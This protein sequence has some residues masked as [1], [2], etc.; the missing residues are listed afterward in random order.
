MTHDNDIRRNLESVQARIAAACARVGRDVASVELLPVSKTVD[1]ARIRLAYEAGCRTFGENKVQEA[2]A[3][4]ERLADLN[5]RWSVIGRLQTNKAKYVARMAHE[6]QALGS[7]KLAEELQRRLEIEGRVL[8]VYIQINSSGEES[9]Y[10]LAPSD[11][12]AF[13]REMTAFERL[14]VKGLMTLAVFSSDAA[15]VRACF[16][17]MR[18]LRERLRQDG[19]PGLSFEGLSMGMSGDFEIAIEEGSTLVRVGQAIFGARALPD[20]HYWPGEGP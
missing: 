19:P 18:D 17:V 8:D 10:G 3:K 9:K 6:F 7:V 20:S 2:V 1:D 16:R 13:A 4:A 5:A 12:P 11:V 15:R 14:R